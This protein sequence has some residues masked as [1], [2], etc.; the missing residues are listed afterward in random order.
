MCGEVAVGGR[1]MPTT[2]KTAVG[3]EGAWVRGG[4]NKMTLAVDELPFAL[5]VT[6]PEH[7][8]EI[9]TLLIEGCNGSIGEFL[10]PFVLMAAGTVC[11]DC[12]CSVEEQDSLFCPMSEVARCGNR[13]A[14]VAVE[15]LVDIIQR[16]RYLYA[17]ADREAESL[18]LPDFVVRILP[19]DNYTYLVERAYI[20]RAEDLCGRRKTL[21]C[22]IGL[23]Y[24]LRE[25]L[26]VRL[27]E[28]GLQDLPPTLFYPDVHVLNKLKMK[29]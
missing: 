3:T 10:P 27:V 26:E 7:K 12:E 29:N 16:R 8:D 28:L 15:F 20:K 14:K 2:D 21:P 18:R 25:Q 22:A 13:F 5:G 1:E 24:K 9:F 19:D 17:F 4:E 6:T 11:L 23:T